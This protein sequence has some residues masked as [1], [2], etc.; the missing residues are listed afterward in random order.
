M[1]ITDDICGYLK[2]RRKWIF[3]IANVV[4][5]ALWQGK[6]RYKLYIVYLYI[7]FF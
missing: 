5:Q 4:N 6:V 1:K 3:I 7:A 2:Y